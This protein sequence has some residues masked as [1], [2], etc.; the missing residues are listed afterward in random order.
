[1]NDYKLKVVEVHV[2]NQYDV[3]TKLIKSIV[4]ELKNTENSRHQ[5][6]QYR[7]LLYRDHEN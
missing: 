6:V 7:L 4:L 3:L 5:L 2:K 1:M